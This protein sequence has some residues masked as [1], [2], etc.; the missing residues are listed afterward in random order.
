MVTAAWEAKPAAGGARGAGGVQARLG[1]RA[2]RLGK[3]TAVPAR[4]APSLARA[5][6]GPRSPS[7][8]GRT[9]SGAEGQ[10]MA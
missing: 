1:G 2:T 5:P 6:G 10:G 3:P 4:G 9:H 7:R 8:G